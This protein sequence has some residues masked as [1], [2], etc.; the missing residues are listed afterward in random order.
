M[1]TG[2]R[3]EVVTDESW[4]ILESPVTYT[5]IYGS[6]DFDSRK[7]NTY[8]LFSPEEEEKLAKAAFLEDGPKLGK[9]E[10]ALYAPLKV[11]RAYEGKTVAVE[12]D[13]SLVYD[14]GQN[15]A[16]LFELRVRGTCGQ[17]L[18]LQCAENWKAGES[19]HPMTNSW[20]EETLSG[21]TECFA[22]KVYLSRGPLCKGG[23]FA[24]SRGG[25]AGGFV[26]AG[27]SDQQ[28][29]GAD[30]RVSLFRRPL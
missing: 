2:T 5:N 25:K 28:L 23:I 16:F 6:E 10:P 24:G 30:R 17:K 20:C 18:R 4:R 29:R 22:P 27:L 12:P 7:E 15:M 11:I 3:E 19:F 1:R 21:E 8:W 14:L 26:S 13:G 9:L